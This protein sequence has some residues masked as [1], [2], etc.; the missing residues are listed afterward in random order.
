MGCGASVETPPGGPAT[1]PPTCTIYYFTSTKVRRNNPSEL[2]AVRLLSTSSE[3]IP[4]TASKLRE[5]DGDLAVLSDGETWK[6]NGKMVCVPNDEQAAAI[7]FEVAAPVSTVAEVLLYTTNNESFGS[8]PCIFTVPG[9]AAAAKSKFKGKV[10]VCYEAEGNLQLVVAKGS[11]VMQAAAPKMATAPPAAP[12]KAAATP[13][14]LSE[15]AAAWLKEIGEAPPLATMLAADVA[16]SRDWLADAPSVDLSGLQPGGFRLTVRIRTTSLR[17]TV[18]VKCVDRSALERTHGE[19]PG[20]WMDTGPGAPGSLGPPR[21]E[22]GSKLLGV[23]H[24]VACFMAFGMKQAYPL[25]VNDLTLLGVT[26]VD[27]G[28]EHTMGVRFFAGQYHLF[29]D[30]WREASGGGAKQ[31]MCPAAPFWPMNQDVTCAPDKYVRLVTGDAPCSWSPPVLVRGMPA[32][33]LPDDA[34]MPDEVE[35]AK[36]GKWNPP[37]GDQP[38]MWRR[39]EGTISHLCYVSGEETAAFPPK[40]A[41]AQAAAPPPTG[42]EGA[43]AGVWP[44]ADEAFDALDTDGNGSLDK[45]E[46]SAYLTGLGHSEKEVDVIASSVDPLGV[47]DLLHLG[48]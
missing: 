5:I 44:S 4:Y 36:R 41:P 29:V 47:Q 42:E 33:H 37:F 8:D 30:G 12:E 38:L 40:P 21:Y 2:S 35:W 3:S 24:G 7:K 28:K 45:A 1:E 39:L 11:L 26:R 23:D 10:T 19:N 43:G 17:G 48:Y 18:L 32:P 16:D 14:P 20:P 15:A 46:L 22:E 25:D 9:K 34:C 27:D 6:T 31:D 13:P